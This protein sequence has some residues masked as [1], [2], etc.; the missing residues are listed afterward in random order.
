MGFLLQCGVMKQ[1][2]LTKIKNSRTLSSQLSRHIG[3]RVSYSL[4]YFLSLQPCIGVFILVLYAVPTLDNMF[5][6]SIPTK[7]EKSQHLSN[8]YSA[9]VRKICVQYKYYIQAAFLE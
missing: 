5:Y 6:Q 7:H 3:I 9:C 8:L 1:P 2:I 4:S